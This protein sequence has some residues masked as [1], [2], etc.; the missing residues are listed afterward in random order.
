M[1][2]CQFGRMKKITRP[3]Y[4]DAKFVSVGSWFYVCREH[5]DAMHCQLGEGI[6]RL[7]EGG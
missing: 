5:F 7:I 2:D 3:A 1:T 4:A 6:C